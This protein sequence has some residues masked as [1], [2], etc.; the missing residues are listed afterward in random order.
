[1]VCAEH[2]QVIPAES[3][4]HV[5]TTDGRRR[6]VARLQQ[7]ALALEA[8]IQERK[9]AEDQLRVALAMERAAREETQ[10]ALRRRDEFLSVA[11]HE[12]RTPLA[13]LT[14][15][16]QLALRRVERKGH[17]DTDRVVHALRAIAGQGDR[18]GRL[19]SQ[20][21]DVSRL[22]A[23][24]LR[25]E[26][27]PT[28]LGDLVDGIVRMTQ[29]ASERHTITVERP[30]ALHASV[31]SLRLEQVLTNLLDNAVKYTPGGGSIEVVL[32]QV[33]ANLAELRVRD[34]GLG[35]PVEKRGG[36][37]ERY[38]QAHSEAHRSG[39][40]L[41]LYICRQIIEMHGG[42]IWAEFPDDG[43]TRMVVQLPIS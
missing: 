38:Y 11:S 1:M 10:A 27:A 5:G 23:G 2:S 14:A 21:L 37:F 7:K 33:G 18:L 34:H 41:G 15:Q 6:E 32:G 24:V 29:A 16:A 35:I 13:T 4:M 19:L 8:E 31:D 39:L 25:V 42:A 20:L 36:I 30:A 40:G 3:Y 26:P 43:G 17:L 12:L 22:E 9:S 28:E